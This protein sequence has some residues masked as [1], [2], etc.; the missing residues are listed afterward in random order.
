MPAATCAVLCHAVPQKFG[1]LEQHA[2][3]EVLRTVTGQATVP[4]GLGILACADTTLAA[5]RRGVAV[6]SV[7]NT[8]G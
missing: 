7:P 1:K 8:A 4:F 2:L 3:P 5:G 6:W